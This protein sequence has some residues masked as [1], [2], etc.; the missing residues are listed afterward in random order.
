MSNNFLRDLEE[1]EE[2]TTIYAD[3]DIE[4]YENFYKENKDSKV[5]WTSK[6]NSIGELNISFDR[7]K[8]YNLYEDYPDNMTE[9]EVE[10]FDN[11]EPYW[12]DFFSW[13]KR[14]GEKNEDKA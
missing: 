6:I 13:R 12:A 7:K 1:D 11:E 2:D 5:W 14:K 8:I 3:C 4:G 9:E 10:I